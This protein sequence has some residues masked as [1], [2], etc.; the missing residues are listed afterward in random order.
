[1]SSFRLPV[2]G[3]TIVLR[4]PTGAEDMLVAEAGT[5]DARLALALVG[6]LAA[7]TDGR[8]I[9]WAALSVTD[10]DAALLRVRQ[11]VLGDVIRTGARCVAAGCKARIDVSFRIGEFLA[12]QQPEHTGRDMASADEPGWFQ[13]PGEAVAFRVP[14]VADMIA[15]SVHPDGEGELARRCIRPADA[16]AAARERAEAMMEALAPS[17]YAELAGTCPECGAS[18][19]VPFDPQ[20]YVLSELRSRAA[21]VYEEVHLLAGR[22]HWAERDI[23]AMPGARRARYAELVHEQRGQA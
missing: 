2:S 21:F 6:A 17:L 10:L 18:V 1:M 9:D 15:V 14:L 23:L 16:S 19:A 12:H 4:P 3:A 22:Y 5:E 13:L 11:A 7:G 20:R 8:P